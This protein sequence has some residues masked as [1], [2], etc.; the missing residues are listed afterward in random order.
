M[1]A[2]WKLHFSCSCFSRSFQCLRKFKLDPN[3]FH[4]MVVIV[5][6]NNREF[7]IF[8]SYIV[9]SDWPTHG[10]LTIIT[11]LNGWEQGY[12]STIVVSSVIES[13]QEDIFSCLFVWL[14]SYPLS[15]STAHALILLRNERKAA[16]TAAAAAFIGCLFALC[17]SNRL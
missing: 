3:D 16:A 11:E 2:T 9:C 13:R 4:R 1:T 17:C 15:S 14:P 12:C 5:C 10:L 6:K 8:T 7:H